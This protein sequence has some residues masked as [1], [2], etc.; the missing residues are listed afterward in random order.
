MK[1]RDGR[2]RVVIEDV[3]PQI[4]CG[5]SSGPARLRRGSR[6]DC[7]DFCGR[8]GSFGCARALP[9]RERVRLALC[10][11]AGAWERRLASGFHR[12]QT[13]LVEIHAAGVDRPLREPGPATLPSVL[14]RRPIPSLPMPSQR[15]CPIQTQVSTSDRIPRRRILRSRFH[16]APFWCAKQPRGRKASDAAG[17]ASLRGIWSGWP[18][19]S[20][21]STRILAM[22][23]LSA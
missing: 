18:A 9:A 15:Q 3:S 8:S 17:C 19:R 20:A 22:R 12:R 5:K 7:G 1:L 11:H 13:W 21:H 16:P 2:Q 14:P 23:N 10:S 4:D 6:G